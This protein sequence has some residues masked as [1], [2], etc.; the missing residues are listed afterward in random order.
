MQAYGITFGDIQS[1]VQYENVN[2]SG[3]D[4]NV[5]DV[6]RTIRVKGEF[7]SLDDIKGIIIRS[8]QG[9]TARLSE[10]ADVV[11]SN[12][13]KQ[14]FARLNNKTVI[15]LNVIKRGGENLIIASEKSRKY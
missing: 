12:A 5:S 13:E 7:V 15:T 3:G 9:A 14:D 11:D 1:A 2:I 6:R 10:I 8:G 4:L